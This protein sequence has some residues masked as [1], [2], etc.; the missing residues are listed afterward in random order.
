MSRAHSLKARDGLF[1]HATCWLLDVT[2]WLLACN[3]LILSCHVTRHRATVHTHTQVLALPVS[4]A[5]PWTDARCCVQSI[6]ARSLINR[7]VLSSAARVTR[8]S[9]L[10]TF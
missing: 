3:V 5:L 6:D 7:Y 4:S 10:I 8:D 1:F 2:C 9:A